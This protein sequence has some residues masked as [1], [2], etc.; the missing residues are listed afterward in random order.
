[1][2]YTGGIFD[3]PPQLPVPKPCSLSCFCQIVTDP[4]PPLARDNWIKPNICLGADVICTCPST[5]KIA[6]A[7]RAGNVDLAAHVIRKEGEKC[8]MLYGQLSKFHLEALMKN[9]QKVRKNVTFQ[10]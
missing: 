4:L 2:T 6:V 1:M 3:T 10:F 8:N 9:G 7:V 5:M